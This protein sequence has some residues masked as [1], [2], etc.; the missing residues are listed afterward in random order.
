MSGRFG[1]LVRPLGV[2]D[3]RLLW[4]AQCFSELGDW[5]TRLAL[6]LV[7]YD[8][9]HSPALSAAVVTVSLVPWV[10]LGQLV[11]AALDHLPRKAVM[12]AADLVRALIFALLVIPMPVAAVFVAAFV[13]GVATAPF[14]GA[15]YSIRVEV[16]EDDELYGGAITLFG[17]TTQLAT[18]A[19][20][21]LGGL[22]VALVGAR[23]T[24]ALNAASFLASALFVSRVHT[25][26]RGARSASRGGAH[27]AD[28][29]RA[30]LADPVLRWCSTLSL[31]SAFAG[32]AVEAI[33][34]PYGRGHPGTVTV[35]AV[36]VPVGLVI[37][38][39]VAPHSGGPSRLLRAAGLLPVVGGAAGLAFFAAGGGLLPSALGF[40]AAGFAVSVPIPAGP[41][42]GRRLGSEVRSPAFSILQGA[43]LGGQAAGAAVGGL[44]AG[45]FTPRL[46]ALAACAALLALGLAASSRLPDVTAPQG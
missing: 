18:I 46:T 11:T 36:A 13:A 20:F 42:V 25:R 38:G 34:A 39:V 4:L 33:A 44:L 15:R 5:A 23:L 43:A 32:M 27:L 35:L 3:F 45:I 9:T 21:A 12:V 41:V 24:F 1:S 17:I 31:S 29:L 2:R 16:T 26:S 30:L 10:G 40:A 22:S 7:V 14:E 8:R 19:G 28:A 6:T 37:A